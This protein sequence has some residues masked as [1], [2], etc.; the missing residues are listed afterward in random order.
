MKNTITLT[1]EEISLLIHSVQRTMIK[2]EEVKQAD[3]ELTRKHRLLL[4]TLLEMEDDM[5]KPTKK[6]PLNYYK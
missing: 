4:K 6:E 3:A 5:S 1:R 2:L